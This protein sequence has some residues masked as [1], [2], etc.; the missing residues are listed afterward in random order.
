MGVCVCVWFVVC[1]VFLLADCGSVLGLVCLLVC[2][3][4]ASCIVNKISK[5]INSVNC[6]LKCTL[7]SGIPRLLRLG[8]FYFFSFSLLCLQ[9]FDAVG[10]VAGR[11]SGL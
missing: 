4:A 1:V 8:C 6:C 9:C 10:W 11:A 7:E 3:F 2:V 5:Y